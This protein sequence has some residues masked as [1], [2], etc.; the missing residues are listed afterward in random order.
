MS[1]PTRREFLRNTVFGAVGTGMALTVFRPEDL[2]ADPLAAP[3][4]DRRGNAAGKYA[5]ELD[6]VM[7]GWLHSAEGGHATSEVVTEKIGPDQ[8]QKKHIAGVKYEDIT[9]SVGLGMS[10]PFYEWIKATLS[11]QYS[12]KSGAIITCDFND[13]EVSRLEWSNALIT[14]VGFPALD[15]ASKDT[16]KITIKISP[17]SSRLTTNRGGASPARGASSK[18]QK[19]WLPSNF[20]LQIPNV[21]CTHVNTIEAITVKQRVTGNAAGE[22][23]NYQKEPASVEVPNLVITL[24]ESQA[25]GFM[26]WHHDFAIRGQQQ[27]E[28]Q[29]TLEYLTPDL[30]EALFTLRFQRLGIFKIGP[31]KPA[32]DGTRRV[33]AEMYFDGLRFTYTP[34]ALA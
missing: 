17:E 14:E 16:A 2:L 26:T 13:R 11:H 30:R 25:Q 1:K 3:Q 7:A 31:A 27:E 23:R 8:L 6:G 4:A 12:R 22:M 19:T 9:L 15:A 33:K 10:Q 24:P 18:A 34:S 20:R 32:S 5:L 29:G 21:D 28:R